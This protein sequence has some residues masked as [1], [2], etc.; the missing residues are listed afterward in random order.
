MELSCGRVH[1][2]DGFH[3]LYNMNTGLNDYS[4][5]KK[6]QEKIRKALVNPERQLVCDE[7]FKK[8]MEEEEKK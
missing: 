6:L 7:E 3:Y 2:I 1:K 8:R 5:N 4:V